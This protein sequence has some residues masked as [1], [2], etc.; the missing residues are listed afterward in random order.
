M[1]DSGEYPSRRRFP[2]FRVRLF[3]ESSEVNER[4]RIVSTLA[5]LACEETR[6]KPDRLHSL[7]T[8]C[9][10]FETNSPLKCHRT[11]FKA[12]FDRY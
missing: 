12:C 3:L 1:E 8:R 10:G 4:R 9:A 5:N 2:A 6:P 7:I 11:R